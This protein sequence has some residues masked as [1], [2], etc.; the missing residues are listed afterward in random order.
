VLDAADPRDGALEPE[1]EAAVREG[2]VLAQVEIP[3]VRLHR[4]P[5]VRDAGEQLVV[6]VL[7][8]RA[9]DD[10]AAPSGASRSAQ[11]TVRGSAGFSFM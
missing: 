11:R 7:A 4:Q 10:L 3:A 8:L 1:P 9:A 6:I 5:F 2:A